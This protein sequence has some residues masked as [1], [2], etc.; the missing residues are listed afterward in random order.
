MRRKGRHMVLL[1]GRGCGKRIKSKPTE[2]K[3]EKKDERK[4]R[5]IVEEA[6]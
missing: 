4:E 1:R 6:E 3:K 5:Y 2:G